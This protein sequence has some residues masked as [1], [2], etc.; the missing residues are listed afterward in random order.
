MLLGKFCSVPLVFSALGSMPQVLCLI[1]LFI[2][3][4]FLSV[5]TC[6]SALLGARYTVVINTELSFQPPYRFLPPRARPH[7]CNT[8][9]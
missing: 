7:I 8:K 4:S 2:H 3:L 1:H 5:K 6:Q 9:M